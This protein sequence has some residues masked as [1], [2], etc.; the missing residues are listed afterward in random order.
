[1]AHFIE[2]TNT[3]DEKIILNKE[4]IIKIQSDSEGST[5]IFVGLPSVHGNK[6]SI[7]SFYQTIYVKESYDSLKS[8]LV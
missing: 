6:D 1:M 4:W 3:D 7:T 8:L 5:R 2:L